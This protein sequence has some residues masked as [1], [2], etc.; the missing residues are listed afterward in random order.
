MATN[1]STN[2]G[3]P[4][5]SG[6]GNPNSGS[7]GSDQNNNGDTNNTPP[8]SGSS[9]IDEYTSNLK[10]I[11]D[12]GPA[13]VKLSAETRDQYLK[14]IQTFRSALQV[15]RQNMNGPDPI[16]NVGGYQS[17]N[18]TKSN[19]HV[20]VAGLGGM[21]DTMDKYLNYLDEFETTIKKA[22]DKLLGNG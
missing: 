9:P 14:V 22:A 15:E 12:D 2:N 5:N 1:G 8:D 19:L 16:G 6:N 17:A 7:S 21:Q 20:D 13:D 11:Q 4:S 18:Q 10:S 3:T